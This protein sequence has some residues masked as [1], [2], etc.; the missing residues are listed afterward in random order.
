MKLPSISQC[1][2]RMSSVHVRILRGEKFA[3]NSLADA[4]GWS[5]ASATLRKWGMRD[6]HGTTDRGHELLAAW[7]ARHS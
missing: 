3:S 4:R 2:N 1:L 5:T 7:R 6:E